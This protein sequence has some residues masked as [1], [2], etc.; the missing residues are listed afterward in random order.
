MAEHKVTNTT[1][2]A[3]PAPW[4]GPQ[5]LARG[6]RQMDVQPVTIATQ[7]PCGTNAIHSA[8]QMGNSGVAMLTSG[9]RAFRYSLFRNK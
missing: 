8:L 3:N 6:T 2:K 1:Y 7:L 9:Q 5:E 4:Y